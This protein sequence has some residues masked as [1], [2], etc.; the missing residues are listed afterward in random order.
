MWILHCQWCDV[1]CC[2]PR[3]KQCSRTTIKRKSSDWG[4]HC[5]HLLQQNNWFSFFQALLLHS[6]LLPIILFRWV[7]TEPSSVCTHCSC[8]IVIYT[9]SRQELDHTAD[10]ACYAGCGYTGYELFIWFSALWILI[11]CFLCFYWYQIPQVI[12]LDL[13]CVSTHHKMS[14]YPIFGWRLKAVS[15]G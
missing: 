12:S 1:Y 10:R 5:W 8:D 4:L 3:A 6:F 13:K 7:I 15:T 11:C 2:C 9:N 14:L